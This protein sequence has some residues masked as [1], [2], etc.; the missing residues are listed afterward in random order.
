M[1][2]TPTTMPDSRELQQA[3]ERLGVT[4]VGSGDGDEPEILS[5]ECYL[6][7]PEDELPRERD[8][9]MGPLG[10][11]ATG[12]VDWG[13]LKGLT[14]TRPVVDKYSVARFSEGEWRSHN[15]QVLDSVVGFQHQANLLEYNSKEGIEQTRA[16]TDRNQADSTRRLKQREQEL[17]RWK[18]E[19]ERAISASAEEI[20]MMQEQRRRLKQSMAVLQL[21]ESIAGE[22]LDRRTG[23]L[24]PELVRDEVEEELIKEM[25]LT[26]E[27]R[28]QFTRTLMDVEHQ[29]LEDKTAKNRLEY[30]WS[31]KKQ[32]NEIECVNV[33]LNNSSNTLLFRPG[34]VGF[35][36]NQSTQ[37]HWE[38]FT[39]ETL[40]ESEITR[41]RSVALRGTLDAILSD[42]A[43]N[44]RAQADRLDMALAKRISC[45]EEIRTRLENE[46]RGMLKRLADIESTICNLKDMIRRMDI[47]MKK[48]QTRLDN[49]QLHRP[50]VENCRDVAQYGLVDEV[51]SIMDSVSAL[52]SQL[53]QAE[54]IQS[55]LMMSRSN[56]EREI[57]V[58]RKTLEIDRDRSK[59][60]RSFYPSAT[61]LSGY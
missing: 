31:D 36:D 6:P 4:K 46:L 59:K 28:E 25:A 13:P 8:N 39:R 61:A 33:A 9:E 2:E 32:A 30:D 53:Q 16:A 21:P 48:A 5:R 60:I 54:E 12:R 14:G 38:T 17:H 51:K 56:I 34:A 52:S 27:I 7:K 45:T 24:D 49:R 47:S 22:C 37:D 26:A 55:N 3:R 1:K 11:W 43:K 44:L 50:R 29:L 20:A 35:P 58:K 18:C 40:E 57:M 15:K 10:P 23:R 19:L 42:A 41:Q